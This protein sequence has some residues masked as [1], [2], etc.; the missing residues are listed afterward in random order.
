MNVKLEIFL[1][2]LCE[3]DRYNTL[4]NASV[5]LYSNEGHQYLSLNAHNNIAEFE[6]ILMIFL[7]FVF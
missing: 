2:S 1:P 7:F 4:V 5:T 6:E 3:V